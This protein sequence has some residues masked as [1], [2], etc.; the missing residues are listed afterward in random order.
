VLLPDV[1]EATTTQRQ[2]RQ[3]SS[4]GFLDL[5]LIGLFTLPIRV[6]CF[7]FHNTPDML[8]RGKGRTGADGDDKPLGRV[9]ARSS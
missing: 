4:A 2:V 7:L 3:W 1:G 5:L 9:P 8:A 6:P